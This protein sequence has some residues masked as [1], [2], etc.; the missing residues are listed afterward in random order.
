MPN[1]Q[2]T[3]IAK[4]NQKPR[5]LI[6]LFRLNPTCRVSGEAARVAS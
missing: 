5:F 2:K 6:F 1:T 3:K 4:K